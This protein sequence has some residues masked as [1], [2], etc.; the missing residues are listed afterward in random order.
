MAILKNSGIPYR[1]VAPYPQSKLDEAARETA[2]S[3]KLKAWD[4]AQTG[5]GA[6]WRG[7]NIPTTKDPNLRR[8]LA[9]RQVEYDNKST[10]DKAKDLAINAAMSLGPEIVLGS[11]AI[12]G[13]IGGISK[14]FK[15]NPM[16]EES[17]GKNIAGL[18]RKP[19]KLNPFV[20]RTATSGLT[21]GMTKESIAAE[22]EIARRFPY[23]IPADSWP[24]TEELNAGR[25]AGL[26]IPESWRIPDTNPV[27]NKEKIGD[28]LELIQ[29][30]DGSN[31]VAN[32]T[33]G[34]SVST[35]RYHDGTFSTYGNMSSTM[36]AGKAI[37]ALH[38]AHKIGDK[39][40]HPGSLSPD[41]WKVWMTRVN[42]GDV[43]PIDEGKVI[44]LNSMGTHTQTSKTMSSTVFDTEAEAQKIANE[45]NVH[46]KDPRVPKVKMIEIGYGQYTVEI[47]DLTY[48]KLKL[49]LGPLIGGTVGA[50]V[51]SNKKFGGLLKRK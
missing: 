31:T 22:R 30:K 21:S 46:I 23:D 9:T 48:E 6:W 5:S 36:D 26:D 24:T 34:G 42:R 10:A 3:N 39:F 29:Y 7:K 32:T 40:A 50:K 49:V 43:M 8:E 16:K 27:I 37:S 20:S 33:T 2:I 47:P 51:V 12:R 17:V 28:H 38:K 35:S 41:S 44:P 45:L 4:E 13:A 18:L 11:P 19:Y 25:D 14:V 1:D 15:A